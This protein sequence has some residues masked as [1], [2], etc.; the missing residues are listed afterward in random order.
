M[1]RRG[2]LPPLKSNAK[3]ASPQLDP[4]SIAD[5]VD[6]ERDA[7]WRDLVSTLSGVVSKAIL[8]NRIHVRR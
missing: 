8:A 2:G 5:R 6:L 7:T 3:N 1:R 4:S